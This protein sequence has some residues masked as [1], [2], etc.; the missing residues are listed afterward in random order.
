M[1]APRAGPD[2]DPREYGMFVLLHRAQI[3]VP[4]F[5]P[6]WENLIATMVRVCPP[7]PIANVGGISNVGDRP[8]KSWVSPSQWHF[9]VFTVPM[10]RAWYVRL[11]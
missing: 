6:S 7:G 10:S 1:G 11:D 8:A 9:V 4:T 2:D 5:W 3:G